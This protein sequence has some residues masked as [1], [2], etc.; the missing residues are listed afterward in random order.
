MWIL[1]DYN[2]GL[3]NIGRMIAENRDRY[4]FI[5]RNVPVYI[6]DL[7]PAPPLFYILRYAK[8]AGKTEI[9]D[10]F[11]SSDGKAFMAISSKGSYEVLKLKYN[12]PRVIVYTESKG[13]VLF[14]KDWKDV[15]DTFNQQLYSTSAE[16][17]DPYYFCEWVEFGGGTLC[18]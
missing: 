7:P 5:P 8:V 15:R 13:F 9:V 6:Y 11:K 17:Y 14:G 3:K 2:R 10:M 16:I 18:N 1:D 12:N 4:E